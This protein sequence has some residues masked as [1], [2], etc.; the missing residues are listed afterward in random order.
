MITFVMRAAFV[1]LLLIPQTVTARDRRQDVPG[2]FDFYVLSLSWS[3]SFCATAAERGSGR[4][5]NA[6]CGV[7]PYA[8]V[9]HGLWP[10][11]DKGLSGIL[12]V[13][14]TAAR[15]RDRCFDARSDARAASN[16]QRVGSPRHLF[17]SD[18][19][20]LFR[21]GAQGPRGGENPTRLCRSQRATRRYAGQC[22]RRFHQSQ[23][24]SVA[25]RDRDCLRPQTPDRSAAVPVEGSAISRLPA[26]R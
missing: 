14:G 3:P 4:E 19:T 22:R 17:G 26:N 9:V 2:H 6:Q 16:L 7:R 8:F 1:A 5:A 20:R 15:P 21:D 24:R 23:S 11:Y 25:K 13:A 10:Q 18:A 12:S